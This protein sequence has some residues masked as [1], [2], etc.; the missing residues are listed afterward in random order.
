MN[1]PI[2]AVLFFLAGYGATFVLVDS[3]L[4]IWSRLRDNVLM[5]HAFFEQLLGCYFCTG[6]WVGFGFS[7]HF[8]QSDLFS[9]CMLGL[10]SAAISYIIHI[11]IQ[12]LLDE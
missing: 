11:I 2:D 9:H 12:R 5:K 4:P 8:Y 3:H 6:F 7:F 10:A 1:L